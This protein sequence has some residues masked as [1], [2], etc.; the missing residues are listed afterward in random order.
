MG[1]S[2]RL[3]KYTREVFPHWFEETW[4]GHLDGAK[5]QYR[6]D[7]L[8]ILEYDDHFLVHT[9]DFDPRRH[10]VQH[11]LHDA[12]EVIAGAICGAA[13][14]LYAGRKAY[15]A[16]GSGAAGIATALASAGVCFVA[17]MHAARRAGAD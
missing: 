4:M 12:P 7:K 8:H 15:R 5:R 9:D 11:V 2:V 17:G 1:W 13:G 6:Y 16:T 14:G 3:P 10:P